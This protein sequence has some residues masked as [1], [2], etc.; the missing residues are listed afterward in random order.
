MHDICILNTWHP[1]LNNTNLWK[2]KIYTI[3]IV[4]LW[5]KN[6]VLLY[7]LIG[8][9]FKPSFFWPFFDNASL[10]LYGLKIGCNH[11]LQNISY[12]AITHLIMWN[13]NYKLFYK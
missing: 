3:T 5:F 8:S 13:V 2:N 7:N 11:V 6:F 12:L 9:K 1:Y 10:A 4:K